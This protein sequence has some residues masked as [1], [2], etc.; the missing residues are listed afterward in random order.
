MNYQDLRENKLYLIGG[1]AYLAAYAVFA[2]VKAFVRGIKDISGWYVLI[3]CSILLFACF[4]Y[5]AYCLYKAVKSVKSGTSQKH[6]QPF[7]INLFGDLGYAC[8]VYSV[9]DLFI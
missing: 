4:V 2:V 5:S 7:W 8:M 1:I 6:N 3:V 9:L